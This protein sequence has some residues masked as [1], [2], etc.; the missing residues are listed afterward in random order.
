[1][2]QTRKDNQGS[3]NNKPVQKQYKKIRKTSWIVDCNFTVLR[4]LI[5]YISY[6]LKIPGVSGAVCF[7]WAVAVYWEGFG[8]CGVVHAWGPALDAR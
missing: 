1:M 2:E 7:W 3:A 8:V 4:I 6:Y 5:D